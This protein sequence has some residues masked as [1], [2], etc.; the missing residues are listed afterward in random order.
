MFF[1]LFCSVKGDGTQLTSKSLTCTGVEVKKL[2][3]I[4][5]YQVEIESTVY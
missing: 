4:I 5:Y 1:F 3:K 2:R